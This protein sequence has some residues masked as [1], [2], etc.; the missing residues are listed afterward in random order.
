MKYGISQKGVDDLNKLASDM[1]S[2]NIDIQQAGSTLASAISS[3]EDGLGIY[4]SQILSMI[5]EL[6]KSE[7]ESREVVDLLTKNVTSLA[8]EVAT[9]VSLGLST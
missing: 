2:L 9:L 8:N 1:S 7:Q 6:N 4:G 5:A 3:V